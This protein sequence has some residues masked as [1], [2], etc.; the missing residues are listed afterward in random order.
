[1]TILT[2]EGDEEEVVEERH[3]V[4]DWRLTGTE[5]EIKTRRRKFRRRTITRSTPEE[6][7][8]AE[9]RKNTV[10]YKQGR[11]GRK[12]KGKAELLCSITDGKGKGKGK[13]RRA[14]VASRMQG[15]LGRGGKGEKVEKGREEAGRPRGG[16]AAEGN[17][18]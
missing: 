16:E 17:V 4:Q 9:S 12:T 18:A 6:A 11:Q 10:S 15:T 2:Q 14:R 8:R 7:E 5:E 1:M 3:R 13:G